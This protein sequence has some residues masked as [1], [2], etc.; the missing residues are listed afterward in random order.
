MRLLVINLLLTYVAC[1]IYGIKVGGVMKTTLY[2]D[3]ELLNEVMA[4]ART[5]EITTAVEIAM[6]EYIKKQKVNDLIASFGSF[7][8]NMSL[9]ELM[10]MRDLRNK[11]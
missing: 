10:E 9:S 4:Y 1:K 5:S 11:I 2:L 8:L 3:R 7:D 6:K